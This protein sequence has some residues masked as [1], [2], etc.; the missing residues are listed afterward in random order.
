MQISSSK[1]VLV[2]AVSIGIIYIIERNLVSN[3]APEVHSHVH[4][5][6]NI[7]VNTYARSPFTRFML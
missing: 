1:V 4:F 6:V 5:M 7:G 2:G 3:S